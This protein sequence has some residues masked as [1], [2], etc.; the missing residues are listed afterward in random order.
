MEK[1]KKKSVSEKLKV[2]SSIYNNDS[3]FIEVTEWANGEGYDITI[4][5]N[6]QS[7]I[8]SLHYTELEAINYLTQTLNYYPDGTNESN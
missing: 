5:G 8:F 3:S 4:E 1:N 6:D 2:F 7:K